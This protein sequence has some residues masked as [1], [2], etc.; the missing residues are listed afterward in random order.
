MTS[1]CQAVGSNVY[2]LILVPGNGGNQL[3]V[4]LD[5]EYNF[6]VFVNFAV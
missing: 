1:M 2:P 4:R 5:R 3:E 6:F